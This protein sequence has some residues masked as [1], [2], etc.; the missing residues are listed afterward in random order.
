MCPH[1]KSRPQRYPCRTRRRIRTKQGTGKQ[2][3]HHKI[4]QGYFP[5][6]GTVIVWM[7]MYKHGMIAQPMDH[8][9]RS[10]G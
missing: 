5:R 1:N 4:T 9:E 2:F 6:K 8:C 7:R 10:V 3:P